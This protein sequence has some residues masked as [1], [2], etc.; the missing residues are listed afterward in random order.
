MGL[1]CVCDGTQ[2]NSHL[3]YIFNKILLHSFSFISFS[4]TNLLTMA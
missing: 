3:S 2:L 1:R 4:S